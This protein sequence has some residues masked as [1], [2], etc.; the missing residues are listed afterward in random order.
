MIS[1]YEC[2]NTP[3]LF[4]PSGLRGCYVHGSWI[5]RIFI[6][7]IL[8]ILDLILNTFH[9][10]NDVGYVKLVCVD[11]AKVLDV[12]R[13]EITTVYDQTRKMPEVVIVG[14]EQ[15]F[16]IIGTNFNNPHFFDIHFNFHDGSYKV[17][18]IRVIYAPWFDGIVCVPPGT[19]I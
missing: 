19:K 8:R 12:I 6:K 3:K 14:R 1:L 9:V 4:D 5:K 2:I 11:D 17:H 18:G 15:M 16:N 10:F 7:F 13:D